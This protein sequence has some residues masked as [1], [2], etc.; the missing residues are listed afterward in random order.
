M[1]HQT[2]GLQL[3]HISTN[4]EMCPSL[5]NCLL[6]NTMSVKGEMAIQYFLKSMLFLIKLAFLNSVSCN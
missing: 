3:T 5:I 4:Y 2:Q 6:V 1:F